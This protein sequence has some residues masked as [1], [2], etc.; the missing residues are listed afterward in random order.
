MSKH[1]TFKIGGPANFFIEITD[2]DTLVRLLNFLRG[3]NVSYTILGGGSNMLVHD[4]GFHGVVIQVRTST[5]T[6]TGTTIEAEAGSIT[7]AVARKAVEH[8]L[9]GFEWAVGVPGTIGGA[10][11]GNAG[12]MGYEMKDHVVEV[13]AYVDGEIVTYTK[14]ECAFRYR[15]SRF[16]EN[17]EVILRVRL[18]LEPGDKAACVKKMLEVLQYRNDTQPKGFASIGCIFKNYEAKSSEPIANSDIPD[19]FIKKGKIPAGWLVDQAGMKGEKR[20]GAMVSDIHGNFVIN[21]EKASAQ[22][23]LSLI[24]EIKTRVYDRFGVELHEEI[25]I[26]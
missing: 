16:K 26:V 13:D 17:G 6:V 14:D 21:R 19:E 24:E 9:A 20:G 25:Q 4:D 11:R 5:L 15:H 7:A 8:G 12:A 1:T 3:R 18:Q 22:D 10:V 2:T 23:V